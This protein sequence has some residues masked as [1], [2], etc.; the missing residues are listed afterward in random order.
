[1]RDKIMSNKTMINLSILKN[2]ISSSMVISL[3]AISTTSMATEMQANKKQLSELYSGKVYSPYAGRSFP[4]IPLWGDSHLHTSLSFDAGA[5]GNRVGPRDAYRL[6]RGEE[7]SSSSGQPIRLARPLDWLSITDHSDGM[8]FTDDALAAS[9]LITNY[10]QGV[11]TGKD[12]QGNVCQLFPRF[13]ALRHSLG[14]GD[15]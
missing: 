15:Q 2:I 7:I 9:P 13:Q 5:F 12:G 3:L 8:G 4:E 1:M 14:R 6:A 10:E 11:L